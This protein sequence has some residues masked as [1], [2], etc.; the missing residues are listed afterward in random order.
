MLMAPM[1]CFSPRWTRFLLLLTLI[2]PVCLGHPMPDIPVRASFEANGSF[3]ITVEVDPRC[4]EAD[5][6]TAPYLVE[7]KWKTLP[8]AELKA[9][10]DKTRAFI[11]RSVA[12]HFST[13]EP[14]V[15]AF[16]YSFSTL[17]NAPLSKADDPVMVSGRWKGTLPKEVRDYSI[18][19]LEG[20]GFSV[21]FLNKLKGEKVERFQV[22]FP[23][24]SSYKLDLLPIV[25]PPIVKPQS[26]FAVWS[27]VFKGALT[28]GFVYVWGRGFEHLLLILCLCLINNDRRDWIAQI[29]VYGI[30]QL[31]LVPWMQVPVPSWIWLVTAGSLVMMALINLL[32]RPLQ[33]WRLVLVALVGIAHGMAFSDHVRDLQVFKFSTVATVSG[34]MIGIVC[35]Q[36]TAVMLVSW[37]TRRL[38]SPVSFRKL[39]TN[40]VSMLIAGAGVWLLMTR[41]NG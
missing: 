11:D 41:L 33:L 10:L 18:T 20:G 23:G 40:P 9:L 27:T 5:P 34:Y 29:K 15:P 13:A 14:L 37:L 7:E 39:V 3:E 19:A 16:E 38:E 35:A 6:N 28:V 36:V 22:L 1:V 21:L 31:L 24:E 4:F 30:C 2:A 25:K 32:Q 8:E 17:E 12:L 26:V